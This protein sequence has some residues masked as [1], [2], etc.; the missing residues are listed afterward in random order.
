MLNVNVHIVEYP[1]GKVQVLHNLVVNVG[2]NKLLQA[3]IGSVPSAVITHF[4]VGDEGAATT[5]SMTGLVHLLFT[6]E[7]TS[8]WRTNQ[9]IIIQYYLVADNAESIE[10]E[11]KEAG[12]FLEDGTMFARCVL[13]SPL[14]RTN[15]N[16][17]LFTWEVSLI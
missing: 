14:Q 8:R 16:A 11:I 5:N 6:D 7:V 3:T 13:A 15:N 1:S 10:K 12:L 9:T 4:A 17:I 2:L